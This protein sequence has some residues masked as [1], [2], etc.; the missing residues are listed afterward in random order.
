MGLSLRSNTLS[1]PV[2]DPEVKSLY[3][4]IPVAAAVGGRIPNQAQIHPSIL[5]FIVSTFGRIHHHALPLTGSRVAVRGF[6]KA[7]N[8]GRPSAL[9]L[10]APACLGDE[11]G[12]QPP[13]KGSA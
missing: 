5:R 1:I 7:M 12:L 8:H 9:T 10:Q 4:P 2:L 3:S 11:D 6:V 13:G